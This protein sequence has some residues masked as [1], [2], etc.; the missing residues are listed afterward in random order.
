MRLRRLRVCAAAMNRTSP[1]HCSPIHR[2]WAKALEFVDADQHGK[3]LHLSSLNHSKE[4]M[5]QGNVAVPNVSKVD[6]DNVND[7]VS[8][9][10]RK[11]FPEVGGQ[12]KAT[13]SENSPA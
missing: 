1:I 13:F 5:F 6:W 12:L 3:I 8:D 4:W 10:V 11:G 9:E 2:K 7:P